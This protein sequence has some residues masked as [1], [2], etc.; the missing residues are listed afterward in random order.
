[1]RRPVAFAL[2]IILIASVVTHAERYT[3]ADGRLRAALAKQPYSPTGMS[4]GPNTMAN[5]GI[6]QILE[7]MGATLRIDEAA[8]TASEATEYGAWKRLGMALGH[9]ADIVAKNE[10]D[11]V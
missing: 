2:A 3:A 7:G 4:T 6:Q 11:P 10:R 5:G 8:L 1:M 9:F